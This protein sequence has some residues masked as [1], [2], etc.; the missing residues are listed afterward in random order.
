MKVIIFSILA[1]LGFGGSLFLRKLSVKQIGMSAFI[2]ET[3]AIV[4]F[5]LITVSL[6]FPFSINQIFSKP[7]TIIISLFT[8]LFLGIGVISFYLAAKSGTLIIPSIIS[9]ILATL[10]ASLLAV[11]ILHEKLSLNKVIGLITA[12]IGLFIFIVGK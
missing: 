1:G 6:I 2:F 9:P 8:G 10:T 4:I 5:A 3:I 11:F 12:I 7:Q